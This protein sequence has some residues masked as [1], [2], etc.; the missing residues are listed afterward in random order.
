MKKCLLPILLLA[1][2]INESEVTRSPSGYDIV[3]DLDSMMIT[4]YGEIQPGLWL[5][6]NESIAYREIAEGVTLHETTGSKMLDS[7]LWHKRIG[8]P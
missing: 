1:S 3:W 7:L 6:H 4:G 5:L 8:L 2:C